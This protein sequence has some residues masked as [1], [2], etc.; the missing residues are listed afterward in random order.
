MT[1]KIK[2]DTR[3]HTVKKTLTFFVQRL[4]SFFCI[5]V[6]LTFFTFFSF[7]FFYIYGLLQVHKN[8][9]PLSRNAQQCC[10]SYG[11]FM[12]HAKSLLGRCFYRK[13]LI[14]CWFLGY[15]PLPN[16]QLYLDLICTR[17]VCRVLGLAVTHCI[18]SRLSCIF[19]LPR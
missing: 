12:Q 7:N 15:R 6:I 19:D 8:V 1:L 5:I 18:V 10:D 4:Q 14:C 3:D 9:L 16:S 17:Q 13:K 11:V 2:Q